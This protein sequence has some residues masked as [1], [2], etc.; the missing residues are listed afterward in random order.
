M[1]KTLTNSLALLNQI[2][3]QFDSNKEAHP[4]ENKETE[5]NDAKNYGSIKRSQA[6]LPPNN[7]YQPTTG[8]NNKGGRQGEEGHLVYKF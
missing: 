7:K 3:S 4:R 2:K 5:P 6:N 8:N 1:S